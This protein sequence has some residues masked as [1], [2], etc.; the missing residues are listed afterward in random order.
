[1]EWRT[2]VLLLTLFALGWAALLFPKR[3]QESAIKHGRLDLF[4]NWTRSRQYIW[5]VRIG[6][7]LAIVIVTVIEF[8]VF[9]GPH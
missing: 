1:M 4:K 8:F 9:T 2:Q 7:I 5:M 6:G 3:I